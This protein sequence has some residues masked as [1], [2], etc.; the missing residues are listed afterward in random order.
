MLINF[1]HISKSYGE[2]Q[3]LENVTFYL[4]SGDR[5]GIV[6]VNGTGKSTLL[7]IAADEKSRTPGK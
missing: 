4:H 1:E 7:K 3:L 2:R 5:I 6:G